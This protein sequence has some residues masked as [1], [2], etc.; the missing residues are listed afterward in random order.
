MYFLL[1][2]PI[3]SLEN[4]QNSKLECQLTKKYA[5]L[6]KTFFLTFEPILICCESPCKYLRSWID[7]IFEG[8]AVPLPQI[9]A[10]LNRTFGVR[11]GFLSRLKLPYFHQFLWLQFDTCIIFQKEL[12]L[13]KKLKTGNFLTWLF[14]YFHQF[15]W[16][17]FDQLM[18]L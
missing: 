4:C 13:L 18:I 9:L 10:V 5:L 8:G 12:L 3:L 11:G 2:K 14:L 1:Q 6:F 16:L 15:I 17:Q 7:S